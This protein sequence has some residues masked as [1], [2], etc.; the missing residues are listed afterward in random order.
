MTDRYEGRCI[1]GPLDGMMLVHHR[2]EYET[3]ERTFN[4]SPLRLRHGTYRHDA[5]EYVAVWTWKGW[6]EWTQP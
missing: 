3:M 4:F 1:G 5:G 2:Q 6:S